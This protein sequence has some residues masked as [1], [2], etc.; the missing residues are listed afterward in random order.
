MMELNEFLQSM[1]VAAHV[2]TVILIASYCP[3]PDSDKRP[4]VSWFAVFLAGLSACLAVSTGLNWHQWLA[5]PLAGTMCL[6]IIFCLLLMPLI[7]GRGNVVSL[8]P[9]KTWSHN[10]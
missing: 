9:G 5:L 10:P 1:R 4:A 2:G 7:A 6:A 3:R 8:F